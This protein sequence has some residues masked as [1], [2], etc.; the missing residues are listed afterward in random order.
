M[1][2]I[3]RS[4]LVCAAA[5]A[6]VASAWASVPEPLYF[7]VC[8]SPQAIMPLQL[9]GG[10]MVRSR[11]AIA[12]NGKDYAMAWVDDS[13]TRLHFQRVYADGTPVAASV[14]PSALQAN[15][16]SA[17]SLVWN[18]SGYGVAWAAWTA[19]GFWQIYFARLDANGV[20]IG[21][22]GKTSFPSGGETANA[23]YPNLAWS[24]T[25]YGLLWTD[26]RN[27]GTTGADIYFSTFDAVGAAIWNDYRI[28]GNSGDQ[29]YPTV[30]WSRGASV[31][32]TAWMDTRSGVRTEIYSDYFT[33]N[34]FLVTSFLLVT[35]AGNANN[36]TLADNGNGLG[37]AWSDSRTGNYEIFFAR[38]PAI[39]TGT[40]G[41]SLQVTNDGSLSELPWIAFT[42]AEYGLFWQDSRGGVSDLWFQRVSAAGATLTSDTQVTATS[43]TL[44]P[45]AAFARN[46]YMVTGAATHAGGRASNFM[47]AW[48]CNYAYTPLCPEGVV[49]YGISGTQATLAW[50]P[51]QDNYTDIA[52]YQVYRNSSLVGITDSTLYTDTGLSLNTTYNYAIRTVNAAQL[53]SSGCPTTSS[54]YVKTNATLL[55]MVDKQNPN[56]LLN[57]TDSEPMNSYNVYRGTSPQVMQQIGATSDFSF[58]D[59]NVL[60]DPVLYFYTVDEP[61]Q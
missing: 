21:S 38:L 23:L 37:M 50:L 40:I 30:V 54:I 17:P 59:P 41:A 45:C 7:P 32:V 48:G 53:V 52:Y 10:T 60:A 2:R 56:A 6:T 44:Y 16:L 55:L 34:T 33:Y 24:G 18:G 12:W 1:V 47:Q 43:G 27:S 46:G 28:I 22:V 9:V 11:T 42:G 3:F 58:S 31:F 19:A 61:G 25:H 20:V 4:F 57:W 49:A 35:G 8:Q 13:D 39:G 51:V 5:M 36:P 14:I 26:Y 15:P 29:T